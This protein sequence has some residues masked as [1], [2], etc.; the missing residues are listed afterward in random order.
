MRMTEPKPYV[1]TVYKCSSC[2]KAHR[3][4]PFY[5]LPLS[6]LGEGGVIWTHHGK[7]RN[8]GE[9]ILMRREGS[10]TVLSGEQS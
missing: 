7:C 6:H 5:A 8:T 9:A 4:M 1:T 2:G 3:R 10:M